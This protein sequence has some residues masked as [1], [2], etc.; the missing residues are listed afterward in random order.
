V[1]EC[2]PG[3]CGALSSNPSRTATQ[4]KFSAERQYFQVIGRLL[5]EKHYWGLE[6]ISNWLGKPPWA[7]TYL[8]GNIL[9]LKNSI[10]GIFF[11]CSQ[12]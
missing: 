11:L 10:Y 8:L 6:V 12:S 4:Q 7:P 2:L 9:E 3:K 5:I 1:A